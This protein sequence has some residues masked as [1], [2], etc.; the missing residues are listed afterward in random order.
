MII[1]EHWRR[2]QTTE[3]DHVDASQPDL[4]R[5]LQGSLDGDAQTSSRNA[6]IDRSDAD[7]TRNRAVQVPTA[8]PVAVAA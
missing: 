4:P 2:D 3:F 5:I 6:R 1:K 7:A 8:K